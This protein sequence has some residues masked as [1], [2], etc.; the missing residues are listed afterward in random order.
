MAWV[1]RSLIDC[2][3][4]PKFSRRGS[5]EHLSPFLVPPG[6]ISLLILSR[7]HCSLRYA[8]QRSYP[9]TSFPNTSFNTVYLTDYRQVHLCVHQK[10]VI[11]LSDLRER[12][13]LGLGVLIWEDGCVTLLANPLSCR[14]EVQ[15][16]V[17]VL[18]AVRCS[19]SIFG[20]SRLFLVTIR[21]SLLRP[22]VRD[23][24]VFCTKKEALTSPPQR[25]RAAAPESRK[26]KISQ[27]RDIHSY[28]F[29]NLRPSICPPKSIRQT[30]ERSNPQLHA[31]VG[32][33]ILALVQFPGG[34]PWARST[35]HPLPPSTTQKKLI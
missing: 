20:K 14:R 3:R 25:R 30:N 16:S 18:F 31:S 35:S 9:N 4:L 32:V 13:S 1:L 21:F 28:L 34:Y 22:T 15:R 29:I 5:S 12:G 11:L 6:G 23:A 10:I 27:E 26:S 7:F 24:W 8:Q 17:D 33:W 19:R 2:F